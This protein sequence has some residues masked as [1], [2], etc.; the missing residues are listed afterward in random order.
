M[1]YG[2]ERATLSLTT[3]SRWR[4]EPT[5]IDCG[6][7]ILCR[8]G[9][10]TMTIGFKDWELHEGAVITLFPNDVVLLRQVSDDFEVEM[11]QF[12]RDLLREASVQFEQTVY[13]LLR[14]DRCRRDR[15]VVTRIIENMF[16]LLKVYFTQRDCTC[17]DE[18]VLYQL[19]AFFIGFYD[20]IIR[21][22][23]ERLPEEGSPRTRALFNK[24]MECLEENYKHSREVLY[25]A[26]SLNI[27]SKYL[28]TIV[29]RLTHQTA[30]A[31]IDQYVVM[32]LK[33][34]LKTTTLTIREIAWDYHFSDDSFFCRYF[35]H[36][37]RVSPQA[38]RKITSEA[39]PQ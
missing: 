34:V 4:T 20:W 32:Q 19:K 8:S 17:L 14:A 27:T 36:H 35:K 9:N 39:L 37:C 38:Y 11:L 6:A 3:L 24:F 1:N 26:H 12:D 10:A 21:N 16:S 30:K 31:I 18:L 22:P 5:I 23:E 28:N 13:S 15:V 2:T 29:R 7:I 33:L 25:Y